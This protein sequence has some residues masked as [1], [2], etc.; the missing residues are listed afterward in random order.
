MIKSDSKLSG[1]LFT[2]AV[3][4]VLFAASVVLTGCPNK[5]GGN[6]PSGGAPSIEET[7]WGMVS[8]QKNGG[9]PQAYPL[10]QSGIGKIQPHWCFSHGKAYSANKITDAPN[11]ADDGIFKIQPWD[12]PFTLKDGK[13]T[14]GANHSTFSINGNMATMTTKNGSDTFV[15]TLQRVASP[16]VEEIKAAH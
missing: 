8:L 4:G 5:A 11:P 6:V 1:A 9:T 12:K 15:F 14:I 7:V 16:S 10:T 3:I 13:L 2:R